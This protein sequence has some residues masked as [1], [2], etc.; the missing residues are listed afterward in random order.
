VNETTDRETNEFGNK[1]LPKKTGEYR[2]IPQ[3]TYISVPANSGNLHELSDWLSGT[4]RDYHCPEAISDQVML[5]NEEIFINIASYA[6]PIASGE[7]TARIVKKGNLL[8]LQYEDA[9]IPFNPLEMPPPEIN[10]P[11]EER[12]IGG[13]GI[14]LVRKMMDEVKYERVNNKNKLTLYKRI[15]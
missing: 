6:Y 7:V 10:V 2:D 8:A 9:G 1:R 14:F 4:L 5:V 15:S 3:G 13:L 12:K 11:L